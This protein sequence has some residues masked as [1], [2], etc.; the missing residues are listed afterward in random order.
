MEVVEKETVL[1]I[2]RHSDAK[3]KELENTANNR[4]SDKQA[5]EDRMALKILE[6][7]EELDNRKPKK[8]DISNFVRSFAKFKIKETVSTLTDE[9][10]EK[11][12]KIMNN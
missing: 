7:Q 12:N 8:V 3:L 5:N 10:K 1:E 9:Q 2:I 4:L 6:L 11:L